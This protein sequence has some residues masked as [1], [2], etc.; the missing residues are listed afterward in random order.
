[1]QLENTLKAILE[2]YTYISVVYPQHSFI[3]KC[4]LME[5][6]RGYTTLL[7]LRSPERCPNRLLKL[8]DCLMRQVQVPVAGRVFDA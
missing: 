8:S 2:L 5:G 3:I 1:M 6:L 4:Q 7:K